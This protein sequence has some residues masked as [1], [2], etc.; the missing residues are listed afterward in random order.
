MKRGLK[1]IWN[2]NNVSNPNIDTRWKED[3]KPS[4][5]RRN[6]FSISYWV[7][8]KRGLKVEVYRELLEIQEKALDE[9]RIESLGTR[10]SRFLPFRRARWKEDWKKTL[11]ISFGVNFSDIARWKEDW[12]VLSI[13]LL[14]ILELHLTRWK[15]DW[16]FST[17]NIRISK[18][19]L[20]SMKRGLKVMQS[21]FHPYPPYKKT[22]WKEDWK[23]TLMKQR[24]S[25]NI[26]TSMK[27][28][29]K[30]IT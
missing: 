22:R 5:S 13:S 25:V 9:K 21:Y 12:K 7:S 4:T 1:G 2:Y 17:S 30:G 20:L 6:F 24:R 28:G 19:F 8:M 15:E 16:K 3:W 10:P 26:I 23:L 27:R 29:L 18:L 14:E 11:D